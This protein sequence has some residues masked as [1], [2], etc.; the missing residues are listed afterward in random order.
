M[1]GQ[2][3][4]TIASQDITPGRTIDRGGIVQVAVNAAAQNVQ[5]NPG[6]SGTVVVPQIIGEPYAQGTSTLQQA[7]FPAYI[8]YSVGPSS[9]NGTIIGEDPSGGAQIAPGSRITLT[10]SVPG[11]VPDTEGTTVDQARSAL[12]AA[13]YSIS[14]FRYTTTEGSNGNVIGTDPE[15]GTQLSPG[16]GVVLVVN[17]AKPQ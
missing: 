15:A 1:P 4:G 11:E 10:L 5:Q 8:E 16:S 17:G 9:A 14:S 12:Q 3:P 13:G 2:Q 6:T 7:G